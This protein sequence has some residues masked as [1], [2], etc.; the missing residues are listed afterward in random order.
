MHG[1]AWLARKR[2]RLMLPLV[3]T[4]PLD[5]I[6]WSANG[7]SL[8]SLNLKRLKRLEGPSLQVKMHSTHGSTCLSHRLRSS[9]VVNALLISDQLKGQGV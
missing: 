8:C 7:S 3:V 6:A 9:H 1:P 4:T 5:P 2:Y